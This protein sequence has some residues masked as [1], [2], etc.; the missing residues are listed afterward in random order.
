MTSLRHVTVSNTYERWLKDPVCVHS[1]LQGNGTTSLQL[2]PPLLKRKNEFLCL[3]RSQ[4]KKYQFLGRPKKPQTTKVQKEVPV[5]FVHN[6]S[7]KKWC[8]CKIQETDFTLPVKG[9]LRGVDTLLCVFK[10]ECILQWKHADDV[11]RHSSLM[12]VTGRTSRLSNILKLFFL[13]CIFILL[14]CFIICQL[15]RHYYVY[16]LQCLCV[17]LRRV[18]MFLFLNFSHYGD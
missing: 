8:Q 2:Q 7:V 18:H 17:F 15:R 14:K 10:N 4:K 12:S 11:Y 6:Y 3:P 1:K 13:R 5:P 9:E 16:S